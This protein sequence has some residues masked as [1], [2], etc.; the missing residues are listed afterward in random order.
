MY[1]GVIGWFSYW[2][3]YWL[4]E[5]L[6]PCDERSKN[7]VPEREVEKVVFRNMMLLLPYSIVFWEIMPDIS[8]YFPESVVIRYLISAILMDG[9]FYGAHRMLHHRW[10]YRWHKQHH[11]FNIAYPLVAVYSSPLEAILCDGTAIGLGPTLFKMTGLELEVWMGLMAIHS[12]LIHSSTYYGRDHGIHH[13]KNMGN[14]GLLTIFD[15]IFCT[16]R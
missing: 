13:G 9:W 8:E 4:T 3:I 1:Q 10:F 15:R 12:L 5:G 11:K 14:F 2:A 6:F 7:I 16:Y